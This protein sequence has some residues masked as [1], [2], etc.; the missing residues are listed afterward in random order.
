MDKVFQVS[1][2]S[3]AAGCQH[4]PKHFGKLSKAACKKIFRTSKLVM[5]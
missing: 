1:L 4:Y 2:T 3:T 5:I